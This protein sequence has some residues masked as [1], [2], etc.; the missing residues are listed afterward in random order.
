[1]SPV[2]AAATVRG[3]GADISSEKR[4]GY[5]L[6]AACCACT[7]AR[8]CHGRGG[9]VVAASNYNWVSMGER[10]GCWLLCCALG[11]CLLTLDVLDLDLETKTS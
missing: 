1:M 6:P 4:H 10:T 9:A 11:G 3:V 2:T 7:G 8:V 5:Q